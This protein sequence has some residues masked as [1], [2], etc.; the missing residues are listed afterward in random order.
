MDL[1]RRKF[2]SSTALAAVTGS[3]INNISLKA[4]DNVPIEKVAPSFFNKLLLPAAINEGS[5]IAITAPASHTS[6]GEVSHGIK[7]FRSMGC[8][9]EVGE[10]IKDRSL[11]IKYLS[12]DDEYRAAEF[13]GFIMRDDVNLIMTARGGYGSLRILNYLD[14]EKIRQ[15]P[16]IIL[17]FSDIT[18]LIT[19]IY[20]KT[21]LI[22]FHG[23]VACSDYSEVQRESLK[24]I[25]FDHDDFKPVVYKHLKAETITGGIARGKLIGGNLS[26]LVSLLGT[27]YDYDTSNSIF[28]IEETREEPYKIDR[29]LTQLFL[30]G[31]LQQAS[32]IVFGYFKNL[33]TKKNFY[34]GHSFTVRQVIEARTAG[35][36]IPVIVGMPIG[37][38]D[39]NI[40]LPIGI[41]AE[42]DTDKKTLTI[43]EN[44]VKSQT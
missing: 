28:F 22:T 2:I 23:P 7:F 16:K 35:L 31:K 3:L 24:Q 42:V 9:V 40:T 39:N 19:A 5:L 37:H 18:A 34:P 44:P 20:K 6:M 14:Y 12:A 4:K 38:H 10:T 29:M 13:M 17:G 8:N 41:N 32:A 27:E 33:D 30:A 36:G 25:I 43:L 26:M 21:G 1:T 11:N 15:H